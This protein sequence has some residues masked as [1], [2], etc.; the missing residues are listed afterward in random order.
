MHNYFLINTSASRFFGVNIFDLDF[1]VQNDSVKQPIQ[2]NSAGSGHV[3]HRRTSALYDQFDHSLIV[4]ENVQLSVELRGFCDC[5]NVIHS[6]QVINFSV[7]VFSIWCWSWCFVFHRVFDFSG[8]DHRPS[9]F[10][11]HLS[12]LDG[13]RV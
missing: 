8:L 12:L 9:L 1:G 5:D 6:R 3:S 13:F 11:S 4:F 10:D 2:R 7:V